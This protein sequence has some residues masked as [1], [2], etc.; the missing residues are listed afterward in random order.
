MRVEIEDGSSLPEPE[1]YRA[2]LQ[3]ENDMVL[4]GAKKYGDYFKNAVELIHLF[5]YFARRIVKEERFIAVAFFSQAKKHL[6]LAFLSVARRHHIQAGMDLRQVLEATSWMIYAMAHPEEENFCKM[7]NGIM[8]VPQELKGE[9]YKWMEAEYLAK[10]DEIKSMR[11]RI[12][13]SVGHSNIIYALQNFKLLHTPE[14]MGY[15]TSYFDFEDEYKE[16]CGL[17]L[18]ANTTVGLLDLVYGVNQKE[19]V[20]KVADD[21]LKRFN[22][23]REQNDVLKKEM[24]QHERFVATQE[25]EEKKNKNYEK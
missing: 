25:R 10:S 15:F 21:F 7:E 20:F 12:N 8:T 3:V 4:H 6:M 13:E 9:M 16:K 19:R 5:E 11:G 23:L 24:M 14:K 22:V 1:T 17:W 18:V 2:I